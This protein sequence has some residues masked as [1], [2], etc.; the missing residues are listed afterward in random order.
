MW[1]DLGAE[2]F[3]SF[4]GGF[5]PIFPKR[6]IL[7]DNFSQISEIAKISNIVMV[8]NRAT[9][10]SSDLNLV[11]RNFRNDKNAI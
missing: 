3:S 8:H 1:A 7:C 10:E 5:S 11:Q 6:I 9:N 2:M 4:D